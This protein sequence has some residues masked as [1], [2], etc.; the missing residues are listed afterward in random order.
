MKRP[1]ICALLL[2][3]T[4][5]ACK[6]ESTPGTADGDTTSVTNPK[7]GDKEAV[8]DAAFDI[9][10]IPVSD[11]DLG[12]FPYFAPPEKYA[13]NY[14]KEA[15]LRDIKEVDTEYFAINGK[16]IAQEGKSYKINIDKPS[17]EGTKFSSDEVL[18]Y[19]KDTI[20]ALGGVQVNDT[21][22]AQAEYDRV[23]EK[24]LIDQHYGYTLDQNLLDRIKTFV[25]RTK[26]KVVWVQLC[27]L[28]QESGRIAV[29]EQ[30][31]K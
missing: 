29:L 8:A 25:I 5:T 24:V 3:L 22:I 7:P 18:K 13:Y 23:G 17:S 9:N 31:A 10:K 28:D 21:E 19:Y 14:N 26:D 12:T 15:S 4:L 11:K 1:L 30:P 6:K 2:A 16:L 27:L 20:A